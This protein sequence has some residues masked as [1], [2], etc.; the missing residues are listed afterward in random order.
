[1]FDFLLFTNFKLY[2][3]IHPTD[4]AKVT[5]FSSIMFLDN[6]SSLYKL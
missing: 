5:G 6:L 3:E 2:V 4:F 1:M